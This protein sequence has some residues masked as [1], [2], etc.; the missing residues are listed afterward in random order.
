MMVAQTTRLGDTCS[1]GGEEREV[2]REA[3]FCF[4]HGVKRDHFH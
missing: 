1:G 4:G 3:G 2:N